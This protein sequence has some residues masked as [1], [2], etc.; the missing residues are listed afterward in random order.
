MSATK[1]GGPRID[2]D[3]YPTPSW[4]TRRIIE[5]LTQ[6][7]AIDLR[8]ASILEPCCGEGAIIRELRASGARGEVVGLDTRLEALPYARGAGAS[9]VMQARA[10]DYIAQ[11]DLAI[12]NPPF[13]Q[14]G[15]IIMSTLQNARVCAFLLRS[16][17]RLNAFRA[18][19]PDEFKLPQR[20]EFLASYRCKTKNAQ[21]ARIDG[22]GW[23]AKVPLAHRVQSCPQ[24]AST[25]L[26][27]STSDSSE[28]SWFV[29][30][31]K[32]GRDAGIVRLLAD[33]PLEERKAL[34]FAA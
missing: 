30:G 8:F 22:C 12:T 18:N 27:R 19:M 13:D 25:T 9:K 31:I 34:D 33:T 5:A 6:H 3:T 10:Q 14:A 20:P 16:A 1:R 21:G 24:C 11:Y 2:S 7:H 23:E 26:Q 29:W 17:F 15:E 28:Y 4:A 32:R